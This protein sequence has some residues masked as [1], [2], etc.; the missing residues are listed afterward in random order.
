MTSYT[1]E[2]LKEKLS[3]KLKAV[4]VVSP[5]LSLNNETQTPLKVKSDLKKEYANK[6]QKTVRTI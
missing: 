3:E 6:C 2:Y 1:E 5:S 4:H